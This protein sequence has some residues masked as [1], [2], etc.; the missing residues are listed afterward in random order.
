VNA[1][2]AIALHPPVEGWGAIRWQFVLGIIL[3]MVGGTLVSY[4]KPA[5]GGAAKPTP[6]ATTVKK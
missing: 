6:P 5:P 4:Y 2:I 1:F 3:A